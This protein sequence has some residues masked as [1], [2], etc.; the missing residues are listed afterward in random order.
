MP[1]LRR[2]GLGLSV[3]VAVTGTVLLLGGGYE[4]PDGG[5][6]RETVTNGTSREATG[7]APPIP[8]AGPLAEPSSLQQGG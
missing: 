2:S 3:V 7:N 4:R 8:K 5:P 1:C 6:V